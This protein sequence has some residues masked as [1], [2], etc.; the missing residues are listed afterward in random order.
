MLPTNDFREQ[1]DTFT[2]IILMDETWKYLTETGVILRT[3]VEISV[4]FT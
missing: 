1:Y 2:M 3:P 4:A